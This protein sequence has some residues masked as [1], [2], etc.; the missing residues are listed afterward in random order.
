MLSAALHMAAI[1]TKGVGGPVVEFTS[2][3]RGAAE[4]HGRMVSAAFD[5]NDPKAV[6]INAMRGQQMLSNGTV[7]R[8][9]AVSALVATICVGSSALTGAEEVT[10]HRVNKD[11]E[12]LKADKRPGMSCALGP[13]MTIG[14]LNKCNLEVDIGLCF[15]LRTGKKTCKYS[16]VFVKLGESWSNHECNVTGNYEVI[17][18]KTRPTSQPPT[19]KTQTRS[20]PCPGSPEEC[21][22]GRLGEH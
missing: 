5:A 14:V 20:R 15:Y 9:I 12:C 19:R 8:I 22:E 2:A 18:R 3:F 21:E 4:V 11:P 7:G 6:S 10:P 17:A 16:G 13:E 1:G